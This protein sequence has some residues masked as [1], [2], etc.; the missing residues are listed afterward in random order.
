MLVLIYP[1]IV[2][3]LWW[4]SSAIGM[5]VSQR[6]SRGLQIKMI[7]NFLDDDG[8]F[9]TGND[10]HLPRALGALGYINL[11]DSGESLRPTHL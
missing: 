5:L 2:L 6:I 4:C 9:N 11:K 8:L 1:A 10:F 3:S 7:Q